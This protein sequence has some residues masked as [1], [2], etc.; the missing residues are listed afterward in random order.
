MN[1][2][3]QGYY[4]FL[5]RKDRPAEV[6]DR[7][8][9]V[10]IKNIFYESNRI[11]GARKIVHELQEQGEYTSRKRVRR[12]MLSAG[13]IP[14]SWRRSTRTT[15]SDP[16]AA[17]FPNLL[18]Q[19]FRVALPNRTWV[20]D[21]T[22]IATDEGWLYLCSFMDLFSRRVVGWAVS[23]TLDRHLAI[24]AFRKAVKTRGPKK[25]LIVHS[26]RGCQYTSWDFRREVANCSALQSMSCPGTP[27][28]NACA[29][30]FFKAVKVECT[31]RYHFSTRK[32]AEA[33]IAKYLLFYNRVRIHQSLG[34]LSPASFEASF[35]A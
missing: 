10:K 13:L 7:C 3:R 22:Y 21:F 31:N 18:K 15:V 29:E 6:R 23:S 25:D 33:A 30:S 20:T 32:E 19:D 26:D 9:T 14:V 12:L 27:Y 24:E 1:V 8:L 28:D 2:R 5:N 4:E 34:Y 17:A 16:N 35:A 11:Y